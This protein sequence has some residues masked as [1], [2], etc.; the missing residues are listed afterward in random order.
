LRVAF[1]ASGIAMMVP[2]NAFHGA[3]WT[4][5]GGFAVGAGLILVEL[6]AM[7]R[8]RPSPQKVV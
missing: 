4:D 6:G 2:A 8:A 3:L 1:A 7:R 5:I